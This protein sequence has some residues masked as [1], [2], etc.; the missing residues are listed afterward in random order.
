VYVAGGTP[1][2]SN[3]AFTSNTGCAFCWQINID[4][5]MLTFE[6]MV[7]VLSMLAMALQAFRIAPLPATLPPVRSVVML[8]SMKV[9]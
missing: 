6:Q 4:G 8:T 1:S 3:C 9:C 2:F 5:H 7:V